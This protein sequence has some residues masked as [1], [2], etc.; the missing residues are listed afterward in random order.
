MK[1]KS[2]Q[3]GKVAGVE[4]LANTKAVCLSTSLLCDYGQ[5]RAL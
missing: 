3:G 4:G 1:R 5:Q 2:F